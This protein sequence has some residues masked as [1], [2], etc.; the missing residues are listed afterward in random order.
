MSPPHAQDYD[1]SPW[2][3]IRQLVELLLRHQRPYTVVGH[4]ELDVTRALE[5]LA[6]LRQER[7]LTISLNTYL[8]YVLSRVAARH[9]KIRTFKHRDRCVVFKHADIAVP[10][11]KR[12][13][14][15]VKVPVPYI[16]RRADTKS[17]VELS[18]ELQDAIVS[19][20]SHD[21]NVKRRR[22]LNRMPF[23]VQ[24]LVYWYIFQSPIRVNVYFGNMGITNLHHLGYD[25]PMVGLPPNIYS[26]QLSVGNVSERFLP[27]EHKRPTLRKILTMGSAF[28][29]LVLDGMCLA[30]V[31]KDYVQA[32]ERAEGLQ[33]LV[34]GD[35]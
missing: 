8:V 23:F 3:R 27:D 4:G 25:S 31:A 35:A 22:A 16:V 34:D 12:L 21:E 33:E 24:R 15:G 32:V 30:A 17:L 20:L 7:Q 14:S 28:D 6:T 2:P 18:V 19:D 10:I 9:E 1:V 26:I 29:H 11:L 5:L 13:P